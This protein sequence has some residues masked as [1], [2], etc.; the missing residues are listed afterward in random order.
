MIEVIPN[1][2]FCI[3]DKK[4]PNFQDNHTPTFETHSSLPRDVNKD[5]TAIDNFTNKNLV[6][7][8]QQALFW[9]LFYHHPPPKSAL[10]LMRTLSSYSS[11][12]SLFKTLFW[13][14]FVII[15]V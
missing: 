14:S 4:S 9:P 10:L 12:S 6:N 1:R 2:R 5:A 15:F 8:R 7:K 13:P 3:Q 11:S